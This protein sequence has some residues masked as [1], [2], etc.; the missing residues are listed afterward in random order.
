[1]TDLK[2]AHRSVIELGG[3]RN[4]PVIEF[5]VLYIMANGVAVMLNNVMV[6]AVALVCAPVIGLVISETRGSSCR[7]TL[8]LL[9]AVLSVY[10]AAACWY[11]YRCGGSITRL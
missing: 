6:T 7:T 10:C 5:L 4:G 9:S 3:K 2:A 11:R 1:M 8:A